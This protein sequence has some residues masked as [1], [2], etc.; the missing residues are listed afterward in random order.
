MNTGQ[1]LISMAAMILLSTVILNVNRNSLTNLM[2]V[3]LVT[4]IKFNKILNY[5]IMFIFR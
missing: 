5:K 2:N 1:M 4:I 3:I